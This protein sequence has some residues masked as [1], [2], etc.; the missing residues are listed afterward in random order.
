MSIPML[1]DHVAICGWNESGNKIIKSLQEEDERRDI[2]VVCNRE[3][4]P[5]KSDK[6]YW[7]KGDFTNQND[8]VKAYIKEC[9]TVIILA[10][11]EDSGGNQDYADCR[12]VLA[13]LTIEKLNPS[14]H[15]AAELINP[16]RKSHLEKAGVDEIVIRGEISGSM[17]SRISENRGLSKVISKLLEFGEGSEF[18]KVECP[19]S[20]NG[21][22][23]GDVLSK[24]YNE[25]SYLIIG[26]EK[27]DGQ[28]LISPPHET[29]VSDSKFLYVIADDHPKF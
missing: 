9:K 17:L 8:L 15:T 7:I 18:Y 4:N 29:T 1:V 6:V 10:D 3:R 14:I 21:V 16:E 23:F 5:S 12:T 28:I 27:Q 19:A 24:F 22:K 26:F 11:V 20:L 25:K 13:V 2:V